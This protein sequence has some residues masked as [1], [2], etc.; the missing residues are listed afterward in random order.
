MPSAEADPQQAKLL[1]KVAQFAPA[2]LTTDISFL[3]P[4]E[5][6]A[7]DLII[8]AAKLLDPIFDRQ[9]WAG[10][11]DHRRKLAGDTS[12]LG[13]LKLAYFDIMRG[14]WDRQDHFA[15]YAIDKKH[16][17][18]AGFYPEDLSSEAFDAYVAANPNQK[19]ALESLF[20]VVRKEGERLVAVPYSEA[21]KQWLVPAAQKLNEAAAKT[22]NE[23]L[24][25]FLQLR[26]KA[27]MTDDYYESDKAWMDLESQVEVTIGPYEV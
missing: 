3:P 13:Q 19:D 18:G 22:Q 11:P 14:P 8:E 23:S 21:Y 20:T 16:P 26:A 25:T 2:R 12:P 15:P 17:P 24:K 27:F 9:A 1:A 6:E 7:L 4:S 10:Y 5:K